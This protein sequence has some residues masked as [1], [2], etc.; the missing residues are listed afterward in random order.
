MH[1]P[2]RYRGRGKSG[3]HHYFTHRIDHHSGA[4][5]RIRR[6]SGSIASPRADTGLIPIFTREGA[7]VA[8]IALCSVRPVLTS[9]EENYCHDDGKDG[10]ET[11]DYE[12]PPPQ[13]SPSLAK[14]R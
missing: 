8:A 14:K 12:N 3:F 6:A 7:P 13:H 4:F 9:G 11:G 5:V 10:H 1:I 2:I